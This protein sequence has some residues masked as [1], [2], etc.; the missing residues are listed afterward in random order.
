[1]SFSAPFI[2]RPVATILLAAAVALFGFV[3]APLLPIAPL[4]QIDF[5]TLQVSTTLPGADPVTI[6][7]S[8]TSPLERQFSQIAGL[9]QLTS[10]STLGSSSIVLQFDLDRSFDSAAQDVQ[11]AINAALGHLPKDLPTP[12]TYRKTNPADFPI[13]VLSVYSETIP[14]QEVDDY[15]DNIVAQQLSRIQ[16][17]GQVEIQGERKPAVRVQADPSKLA[18]MGL[19][20]EDVR[21]TIA[22]GTV[23]APKG[24]IETPLR[25]FTIYGNDQLTVAEPWNDVIIAYRNGAPV[26]IR[27]IGVAVESVENVRSMAWASGRSAIVLP[28]FK[29]PGANVIDTVAKIKAALPRLQA[30]LPP[31]M[32]LAI[33]VDR[34]VTIHAAVA[35]LGWT[36]LITAVLVVAVIFL[37]LGNFQATFIPSVAVPLSLLGAC[38]L[39][40]VLGFSLNNLSLMALTISVGFVV[41][42]AIVMFENIY[43]HVENGLSPVAA[44]LKGARE[45]S[46]T[47]ISISLSLIAIFIPILFMS[48]LVG[49]LLREFAI[50][51]SLMI[52]V[53]MI[54][55]LT[56][57]P[58]M[59]AHILSNDRSA[60]QS[61]VARVFES[62]LAS[63][64]AA[65]ARALDVVLRNQPATMVV[66]LATVVAAGWLYIIIPK[67]FF[68]QQDTGVIYGTTESAED[69]S[70]SEMKAR[71]LAVTD[72]FVGDPDISGWTSSIGSLG[73]SV[74]SNGFIRIGLK[75]HGERSVSASEI[76]ARLQKKAAG[77][78]DVA[79]F[80]QS[81]Q[82]LNIGGRPSRTQYQ[83]T[84]QDGNIDELNQWA[85]RILARLK[86]LP[87][88]RDVASDLQSRGAAVNIVIDR[89]QASRF[90]ITPRLIDD[91]LY[92][93]F[94]Q[95]Q[96]TQYFTQ[97][98]S[99]HVV[100]EVLPELQGRL[101][102]LDKIYVRSPATGQQVPL[103]AFLKYRSDKTALLSINHQSQFP[104]VTISFNL[105]P[106]VALGDAV[107]AIR[108]AEADMDAPPA[109]I[110][111]FQGSAQA[112]Q[113]AL[114]SQPYLILAALVAAYI[115]LGVLYESFIHPLTIL[116]TLPSAG[117]GA[118]MF[119]ML[120]HHDMSLI[121]LIGILLLIGIVKKNGIMI[122]DFAIVG[123]R[124]R[125]LTPVGAIR[126]ACLLRFR[127]IMMT[128]LAAILG[129]VPLMLASGAGSELRQPLGIA[130]VGGL[131]CS[132]VLTLFTTP[133]VYLAFEALRRGRRNPTRAD[134]AASK[135]S[136]TAAE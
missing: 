45:I 6:A 62:V 89:D 91:T 114:A 20:L 12:P 129:G 28:I 73:S 103:G 132:Q 61:R 86:D 22:N 24:T 121:A 58:M 56:L 92:D 11:A 60:Q 77:L 40:Y 109:L 33:D 31:A 96:V 94:G 76:M 18:A 52:F 66:F 74:T 119:L 64:L 97:L 44:A 19:S 108:A 47:I 23:D 84:L 48:G 75:P 55:S 25:S 53:S 10:T 80:M 39:M 99:Y 118:L 111:G 81:P 101:D 98:N 43:R 29:L 104:A 127:P 124:D 78:Q 68:P 15:A 17:V 100:L 116:S 131:L 5:P 112:F 50:T 128:T 41:D 71:Q 135:M 70:F 126:E 57:T 4:P 13:L 85:P 21:A 117:A 115:I 136:T 125:K 54:I 110:R 2:E 59:C 130:M 90:G 37:F 9:N 79:F 7:S 95:R 49:R 42:D 113:K 16:G 46:F 30:S 102:T 35:D 120:F 38:A 3:S 8:V 67:G 133:V 107:E 1:M 14:L 34:T 93:A 63:M 69:I 105:A 123:Q 32:K 83:Y 65:Y 87:E 88:L 72:T 36:L 51:V 134:V 26:R 82:E 106:G 122:V 27:D